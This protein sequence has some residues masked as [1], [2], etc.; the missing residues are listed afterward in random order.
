MSGQRIGGYLGSG[1]AI[2]L[3]LTLTSLV[4]LPASTASAVDPTLMPVIANYQMNESSGAAKM[5]DSGPNDLDGSIGSLVSTGV[6]TG[7]ATGYRFNA[8]SPTQIPADTERLVTVPDNDAL[9][10]GTS[11]FAVEFRYRSTVSWGNI[12]QKGQNTT[13]GGYFK[14][15]QPNGYMTCLIKDVDGDTLG[16]SAPHEPQFKTND[17]DWH[18]IRC[19][20]TQNRVRLFVDGVR[21][22]Q[23]TKSDPND[24]VQSVSNT[25]VLSIGGKYSCDQIEVSCDYFN[26][27]IDYVKIEK[28]GGSG[29]ANEPPNGSFTSTCDQL[30]CDFDSSSS[31]DPDGTIVARSWSFGDG[32][33]GNGTTP[34]HTYTTG[35][36]YTVTLT[37]TDDDGAV[38]ATSG[39]VTLNFAPDA[40]FTAACD[41]TTCAFDSGASSD[42]DGVITSRSWDFGDGT[43]G[44]GTAPSHTYTTG[45]TYTV[46]LTVTDDD[47]AT[48]TAEQTIA[49]LSNTGPDATFVSS[50]GLLLCVFDSGASSDADGVITSRSWDF[51]DGTT[52]NG[53]TPSHTYTT[54]GTY[55]V[56]LTVTDDDGATSTAEQ[57]I[58]VD[59]AASSPPTA[60]PSAL[61]AVTPFRLFDTRPDEAAPGPKGVI[62]EGTQIDVAVAGVGSVPADITAV[63][64]NLTVVA[65]D[66]PSYITAWPTGDPRPTE[67]SSLNVIEP[68]AVRANLAIVPVGDEGM[69]SL[70][71]LREAHLIGDVVGYFTASGATSSGR[72]VTQTPTRLLDT[73]PGSD[74]GPK[75]RIPAGGE[76]EVTIA[77]TSAIPAGAGAVLVNVTITEPSA[78]AFLTVW[79]DGPRPT[80]S[81]VNASGVGETSANMVIVPIGADGKVRVF[82]NASTH[83]VIDLL[84][85]ATGPSAPAITTGLFVPIDPSR[86]FD[87]RPS[88]P[89]PGPKGVI[90]DDSTITVQIADV[91][92]I[93][94]DASGVVLNATYISTAP[95]YVTLWATGLARPG[96]SNVNAPIGGDV[97]ANG[98]I[99][100][101]GE[102]G[103][104]DAYA[105][106][107]AHLLADAFGY[108]TN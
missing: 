77:D 48:S 19:E 91:G 54:G 52:G 15:E 22:A 81:S 86:I 39:S 63:A 69:I 3:A 56:T 11:D 42:A 10:F 17:G 45:G 16:A 37:V 38:D 102:Q 51:G 71:S 99:V 27:N 50:C 106:T 101:I 31:S 5:D 82:S 88:E 1:V 8:V 34:S 65:V 33:T 68:G 9:D 104:I 6:G 46:T 61:T 7:G 25:K 62:A 30:D 53:A 87:T 84:G 73:R 95:G 2:A 83:V 40:D 66:A 20:K 90:A 57:T 105:L 4:A 29:P 59:D 85:Y 23:T 36:T 103:R 14:F 74:P 35:G 97:R 58:V 43:T 108:L 44:N 78:P 98:V 13:V 93:P 55:T 18:T 32:T 100:D 47:G 67:L 92:G 64:I 94:A 76:L 49:P 24:F 26:G 12:V 72:I 79:P 70:Y 96:T 28:A 60:L 107:G 41:K 89:A 80:A 21:A 75:G